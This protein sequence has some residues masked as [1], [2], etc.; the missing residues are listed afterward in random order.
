M[1]DNNF[2]III[3]GAGAA[4]LSAA[5]SIKEA[6]AGKKVLV[7][8]LKLVKRL[9]GLVV[10]GRRA[11]LALREEEELVEVS[12]RYLRDLELLKLREVVV[13]HQVLPGIGEERRVNVYLGDP[14]HAVA[15]DG[16][17]LL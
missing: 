13:A 1:K 11:L 17:A 12:L 15:A 2:D 16:R 9:E 4:G 5:L 6:A 7:L 14:V 3:I 10:R 8:D